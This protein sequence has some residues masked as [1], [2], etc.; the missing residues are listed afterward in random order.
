MKYC[1]EPARDLVILSLHN[2]DDVLDCVLRAVKDLDLDDAIVL[3]GVGSLKSARVHVIAS[4][5][6]PPGQKFIELPGPLEITQ[7][8]CR[9][10]TPRCSTATTARGAATSSRGA[11]C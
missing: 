1:E 7:L 8:A 10:Y 4:N 2:G 3:T 11:P 6:Y 9:T 5:N